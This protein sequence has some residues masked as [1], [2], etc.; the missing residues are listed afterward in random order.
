[1][2]ELILLKAS[3]VRF[4]AAADQFI[5]QDTPNGGDIMRHLKS[6]TL[7]AQSLVLLLTLGGAGIVSAQSQY[8]TKSVSNGPATW[9]ITNGVVQFC[10]N[11]NCAVPRTQAPPVPADANLI[12]LPN[13]GLWIMTDDARYQIFCG[14]EPN[15]LPPRTPL[16]QVS[17]N[18]RYQYSQTPDNKLSVVDPRSPRVTWCS[19]E[20]NCVP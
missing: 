14:I 15:C 11:V 4:V 5:R 20:P 18:L 12:M 10:N 2:A 13:G 9:N 6:L 7:S 1:M 16:T 17:G 8:L 3:H 19:Y